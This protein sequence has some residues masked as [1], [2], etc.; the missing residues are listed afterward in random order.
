MSSNTTQ[1][2][3]GEAGECAAAD[4]LK[5]RGMKIVARNYHSRFGEIDIIAADNEYIVFVEVKTRRVNPIVS[6]VEAVDKRKQR[7]LRLTAELYLQQNETFLQPRFDVIEVVHIQ[8]MFE[9]K[10][11]IQNAF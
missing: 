3:I 9:I 1:K 2:T 10:Q 11:H 6:G 5:A 7:K 8:G 4:F